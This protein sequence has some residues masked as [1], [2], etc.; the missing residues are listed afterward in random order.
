[1]LFKGRLCIFCGDVPGEKGDAVSLVAASP[2]EVETQPM[3]VE[4]L[5][6]AIAGYSWKSADELLEQHDLDTPIFSEE[7]APLPTL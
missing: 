5:N 4:D 1:M 6:S 2:D 7:F 3:D